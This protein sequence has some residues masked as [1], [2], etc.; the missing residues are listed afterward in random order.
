MDKPTS[1]KTQNPDH[2]PPTPQ[3]EPR[4]AQPPRRPSPLLEDE[5]SLPFL[6]I[7]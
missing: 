6:P 5:P 2:Q 1:T 3:P 7:G 4:T